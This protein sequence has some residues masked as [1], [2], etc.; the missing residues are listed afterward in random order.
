[1]IF[2]SY[3]KYKKELTSTYHLKELTFHLG[4]SDLSFSFHLTT[5]FIFY[6]QLLLMQLEMIPQ[7]T[8]HICHHN[9]ES[10]SIDENSCRDIVKDTYKDAAIFSF[11][12]CVDIPAVLLV[13]S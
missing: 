7:K 9:L 12:C 3:Q 5:F 11:P 1:M 4:P 10:P 2:G 13:D 6:L 8:T